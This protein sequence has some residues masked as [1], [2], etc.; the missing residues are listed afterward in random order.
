METGV[1]GVVMAL[2]RNHVVVDYKQEI[3]VVTI[4]LLRM[5]DHLVL[6]RMLIHKHA[7]LG[8]VQV[9]FLLID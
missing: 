8:A 7:T 2:V 9:M 1:G 5:E 4:H 6:D 3:V